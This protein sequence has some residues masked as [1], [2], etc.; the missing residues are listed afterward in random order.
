MAMRPLLLVPLFI[1]SLRSCACVVA[2]P[3]E[4][5][6]EG[7]GDSGCVDVVAVGDDGDACANVFGDGTDLHVEA[8]GVDLTVSTF[9]TDVAAAQ[10]LDE[11]NSSCFASFTRDDGAYRVAAGAIGG[12]PVGECHV[13]IAAIDDGD[14][15]VVDG[16]GFAAKDGDALAGPLFFTFGG[17]L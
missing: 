16:D 3:G 17:H 15:F 12:A 6:G 5:E 11:N 7:E 13:V 8:D 9:G 2:D 10:T 14:G 1:C 4:G